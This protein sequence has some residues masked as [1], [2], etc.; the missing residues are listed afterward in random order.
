MLFLNLP[1]IRLCS[2]FPRDPGSLRTQAL[3]PLIKPVEVKTKRSVFGAV[4]D[5][6]R[7][8]KLDDGHRIERNTANESRFGVRED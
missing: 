7:P 8:S 3:P 4:D 6:K 1:N 2:L 5:I